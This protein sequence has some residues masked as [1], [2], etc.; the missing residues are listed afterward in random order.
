M[1]DVLGLLSSTRKSGRLRLTGDRGTG[2]LWLEDGALVNGI[3]GVETD[4]PLEEMVFELMRF[5][6]GDLSFSADERPVQAGEPQAVMEVVEG[7]IARLEEWRSIEAVVPSLAHIVRPISELPADEMTISRR[8]WV[9]LLA[10]GPG[11]PVGS[12][13]TALELGEIDGSREVKLLVDR[14]LL[15]VAQ[16]VDAQVIERSSFTAEDAGVITDAPGSGLAYPFE[17][18]D[19]G[20]T[21]IAHSE[22]ADTGFESTGFES[23]GFE[24]TGFDEAETTEDHYEPSSS[25]PS[26]FDAGVDTAIEFGTTDGAAASSRSID[27]GP[28]IPPA[29]LGDEQR[30]FFGTAANDEGFVFDQ[31]PEDAGFT[32]AA[33]ADFPRPAP[34]GFAHA[35]LGVPGAGWAEERRANPTPSDWSTPPE[36]SGQNPGWAP[37]SH[38]DDW[39]AATRGP[40]GAPPVP[41]RPSISTSRPTRRQPTTKPVHRS[42]TPISPNRR[43]SSYWLTTPRPTRVAEA[44]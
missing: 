41:P 31:M 28:P 26:S 19:I 30:G 2:S 1:S 29:P 11:A 6:A 9:V 16:P 15:V 38:D 18:T 4:A 3:I 13:C 42:P 34:P 17:G 36:S 43:W 40:A 35:G 12:V 39:Q 10:A 20:E 22:A 5:T 32:G 8:D 33:P 37:W 25:E 27:F 23:T 7:A 21:E 44:C 24:S 14:G